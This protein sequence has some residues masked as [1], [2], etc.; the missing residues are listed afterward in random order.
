MKKQSDHV[1]LEPRALAS[2]GLLGVGA[3]IG[4]SLMLARVLVVAGFLIMTLVALSVFWIYAKGLRPA[5]LTLTKRLPYH[6]PKVRE[7]NLHQPSSGLLN[8]HRGSRL[9]NC[10]GPRTSGRESIP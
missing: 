5:Y 4:L 1:L 7:L 6:G 8:W 10:A 2:V 9:L 3:S